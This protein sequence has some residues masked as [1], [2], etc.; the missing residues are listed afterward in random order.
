MDPYFK[1]S[2]LG[3]GTLMLAQIIAVVALHIRSGGGIPGYLER[4]TELKLPSAKRGEF[5][6][7]CRKRLTELGFKMGADNYEYIQSEPP[8]E[9]FT[10]F[11]LSKTPKKVR[12]DFRDAEGGFVIAVL[13]VQYTD[14][15]WVDSGES[16]YAASLLDYLSGR[17][18]TMRQ[19]PNQSL[20]AWSS[21][22]G[23]AL[24]WVLTAALFITQFRMLWSAIVILGV[25]EFGVGLAALAGMWMKP[26]E[27][28]GRGKAVLG[29]ILNVSA[30][31]TS[32]SYVL[33][34]PGS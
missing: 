14:F 13:S 32:L 8:L 11:P 7:G 6:D 29:V 34:T 17:T 9:N 10:E 4:S 16:N 24:A 15:V 33:S 20:T 26:G 25:I 19:V 2:L 22:A 21:L 30:V 1:V 31:I 12:I 28:V 18:E 5:L 23:G 27:V 3:F